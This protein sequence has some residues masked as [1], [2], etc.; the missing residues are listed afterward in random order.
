MRSCTGKI[1]LVWLFIVNYVFS[2]NV[3]IK[4]FEVYFIYNSDKLTREARNQIDEW[5]FG[6]DR[7]RLVG[8]EL[9][10]H[11]DSMGT[12]AYNMDL[13]RRRA[14][15]VRLYLISKGLEL[16]DITLNYYGRTRPK[17]SNETE[18]GK[19]KNRRC[20]LIA[21]FVVAEPGHSEERIAD[22]ELK[23][24]ERYVLPNLHFIANQVVPHWYSLKVMN[25]LLL[26][27]LQRRG[28][29]VEIQGHV[30]C[31][32]DHRLSEERARFITNFLISHGVDPGRLQYK[33]F[34]NRRPAE[35][36][37]NEETRMKNRRIEAFVLFD[38]GER[39][40]VKG[41]TP[42]NSWRFELPGIRFF[43]AKNNMP[44]AS[45]FN[46]KLIASDI[47]NSFGY[48]YTFYIKADNE[49]LM[50]QRIAFVERE[51]A[52][53]IRSGDKYKVVAW[54]DIP[55]NKYHILPDMYV[56]IEKK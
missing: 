25:E 12:D 33:G 54:E 2:Q 48:R 15:N 8:V 10:G 46:L 4:S 24:G 36:E 16:K 37:T 22:L 6:K 43:P 27:L 11:C 20:E 18:E 39:I 23:A 45:R 3:E 1:F 51:L 56:L 29:K 41:F 7:M 19:A 47:E 9:G 40:E 44:P 38:T 35:K 5:L 28:L 13:S 17:Y 30:C 31:N 55:A 26:V 34:G 14:E 42:V 32:N 52:G 21:E 53:E 49:R 50:K